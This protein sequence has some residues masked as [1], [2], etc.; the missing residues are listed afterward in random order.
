MNMQLNAKRFE[1]GRSYHKLFKSATM[2]EMMVQISINFIH[3]LPIDKPP[4][5]PVS[6]VTNSISDSEFSLATFLPSES[7]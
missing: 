2:P 4:W 7:L 6:F 1:Q 3:T 5:Q